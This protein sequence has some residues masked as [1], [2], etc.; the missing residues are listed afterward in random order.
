MPEKIT[1]YFGAGASAQ[2]IPT[3]E[4]LRDRFIDLI[5]QLKKYLDNN[6][7]SES[8][9]SIC[10]HIWNHQ[11][12][13][14]HVIN[15]LLWLHIES[16]NHQTV[17]T[18]ARKFYVQDD[19]QSLKRLKRALI[20]YFYFE[21][22]IQFPSS[23]EESSNDIIFKD[24]IDKRYDSLIATICD[25]DDTGNVVMKKNV[26]LITWNYDIQI[27]LCL[28]NYSKKS[29]GETKNVYNIHPNLNSYNKLNE[30]LFDI[31]RFGV[32]K[33]NGNAFFDANHIKANH[34]NLNLYDTEQD[35]E[36]IDSIIGKYLLCFNTRFPNGELPN[37]D[38]FKYFNFAWEKL[39]TEKYT[40]YSSVVKTAI[41]LAAQTDILIIVGYSFPFFNSEIDRA[42]LENMTPKKIIIQDK[43][44]D[45]IESKLK[46]LI[47]KFKIPLG[48]SYHFTKFQIDKYF[49]IPNEI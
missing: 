10:E 17:D 19:I 33:L 13:L 8:R 28:M 6:H 24:K 29:I 45:G 7:N 16:E 4:G 40:G 9:K 21:Q 38:C 48:I 23:K 30:T 18:L 47:P 32:L 15:D 3:I 20:T 2:A 22:N 35:H 44:P 43:D 46:A 27:D 1:Y 37:D 34:L 42:I 26:K 14:N 11:K 49:P 36:K 41:E 25:K 12:S 5:H 31:N 39:E